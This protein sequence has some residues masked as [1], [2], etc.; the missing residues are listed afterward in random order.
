MHPWVGT[1]L[2]PL[3]NA[4]KFSPHVPIR[5]AMKRLLAVLAISAVLMTGCCVP[6]F[7]VPAVVC[8]GSVCTLKKLADDK[9]SAK[10]AA[11]NSSPSVE[12]EEYKAT[13]ER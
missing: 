9:A 5:M 6:C 3:I 4:F 8:S 1:S 11:D 10:S 2:C 7:L 13:A 12:K